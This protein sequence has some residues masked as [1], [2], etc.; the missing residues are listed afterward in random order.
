MKY[1]FISKHRMEFSVWL[2]C[3]VLHVGKSA[4]YSWLKAKPNKLEQANRILD[5][6]IESLFNE[7][8]ARYG[9]PRITRALNASMI[10]CSKN[11]VAKRMQ[12]LSLRAKARKK[13]RVTTDSEHNHPVFE[14]VLGRNFTSQ[15]INQKWAG[16]ITYIPTKEGWLYL[17]VV[18]DL[19]S[20][21]IIGWSMSHRLKKELV[22]DSLTMALFRRKFPQKVIVHSDR[23][24]QYC[25]K[26]YRSILKQHDL[27]GS[28]SRK[29]NCWDNAPSESFFHTLKVEL[30]QGQTFITREQAKQAIFSYMESYYNKKRMHSSIDYKT[31]YE[32]ELA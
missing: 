20:R 27:I 15:A 29:G 11:R 10:K 14:N 22:C 7:H 23:G 28:M 12:V 1:M 9:A 16:D 2:M 4:Y 19:Y 25:S 18:L 24:S 6:N 5:V 26:S 17:C 32:M 3:K 8:K 31:P 13:F 21:A 30:V